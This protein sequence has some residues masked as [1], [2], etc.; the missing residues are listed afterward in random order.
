MSDVA[1]CIWLAATDFENKADEIRGAVEGI[2]KK[3]PI[4][5]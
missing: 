5:E 4:Y 1:H 3:Y 2:C